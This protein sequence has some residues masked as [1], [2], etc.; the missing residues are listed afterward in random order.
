MAHAPLGQCGVALLGLHAPPSM[1]AH[2]ALSLQVLLTNPVEMFVGVSAMAASR[3]LFDT[4]Y[5]I[6]YRVGV[7]RG[8]T[9][10]VFCTLNCNAVPWKGT[11]RQMAGHAHRIRI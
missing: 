10:H 11:R 6:W 5:C 7:H 3:V 2:L 8:W 1:H 4:V 9:L